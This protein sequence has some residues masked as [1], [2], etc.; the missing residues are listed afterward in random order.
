M[1]ISDATPFIGSPSPPTITSVMYRPPS[2]L[3]SFQPPVYGAECVAYYTVTAIS[4]ERNVTCNVTSDE[5]VHNCSIHNA[6]IDDFLF[7]VYSVTEGIDGT[8]NYGSVDTYC[9]RFGMYMYNDEMSVNKYT[10]KM[11]IGLPFPKNVVAVEEECGLQHHINVS[12]E[13]SYVLLP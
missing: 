12:W 10:S 4:E 2:A 7:S 9:G 8:L 13:V 5:Y 3:V 6:S 11:G 1:I